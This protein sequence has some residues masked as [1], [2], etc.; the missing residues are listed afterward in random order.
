MHT[1][2]QAVATNPGLY[3]VGGIET[4]NRRGREIGGFEEKLL[5]SKVVEAGEWAGWTP[6]NSSRQPI[7]LC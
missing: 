4:C 1:E 7:R 2:E 3:K 6:K 5:T